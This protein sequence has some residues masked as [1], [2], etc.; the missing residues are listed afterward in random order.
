MC[1]QLLTKSFE[2]KKTSN[3]DEEMIVKMAK[4]C[5]IKVGDV[6]YS[7]GGIEMEAL[8]TREQF[9]EFKFKAAM[10]GFT[11]GIFAEKV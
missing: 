5:G 4:E 6:S 9:T 3:E 2:I 10:K 7:K 8:G 1:Y 11:I